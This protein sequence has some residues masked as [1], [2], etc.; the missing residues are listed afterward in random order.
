[1]FLW[2]TID[3]YLNKIL[4]LPELGCSNFLKLVICGVP[5]GSILGP[6]L[7]ILYLNDLSSTTK[8]SNISMYADNTFLLK[9]VRNYLEI[10]QELIPEFLKICDWLKANKLSLNILKTELMIIRNSRKFGNLSEILAIRVEN[11]LIKKMKMT[12]CLGNIIDQHLTWEEH[13]EYVS[14]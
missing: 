12:K 11:T 3:D 7:F 13:I 2:F 1:M 5:Q 8:A 9:E 4:G 10:R 6:L 14:K